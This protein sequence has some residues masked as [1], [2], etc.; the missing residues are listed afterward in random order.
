MYQLPFK[1]WFNQS[2]G[3]VY[4]RSSGWG[5]PG[6]V[7]MQPVHSILHCRK[8]RCPSCLRFYGSIP[9]DWAD[10]R[11]F[12]KLETLDLRD[13]LLT[14]T[15]PNAKWNRK[16]AFRSLTYLDLSTNLLFGMQP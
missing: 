15:L 10:A 3:I 12:L 9:G 14:G 5:C 8:W 2:A 13:N 11:H 7:A 1:H 6:T 16:G 4:R